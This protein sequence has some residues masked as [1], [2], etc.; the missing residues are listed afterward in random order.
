MTVFYLAAMLNLTR[1]FCRERGEKKDTFL[2]LLCAMNPLKFTYTSIRAP[3]LH[4]W[5]FLKVGLKQEQLILL[6][7][8]KGR[9]VCCTLWQSAACLTVC[10]RE[11]RRVWMMH[12]RLCSDRIRAVTLWSPAPVC[13][14]SGCPSHWGLDDGAGTQGREMSRLTEGFA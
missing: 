4:L 2:L 12:M 5:H 11:S 8:R 9:S 10:R 6:F 14:L 3:N 7:I 1:C 13:C